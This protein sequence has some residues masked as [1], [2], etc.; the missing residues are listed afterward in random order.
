MKSIILGLFLSSASA[1]TVQ[2]N[3]IDDSQ[4]VQL[5]SIQQLNAQNE[6][7]NHMKI[8]SALIADINDNIAA[9]ELAEENQD[10]NWETLSLH[11]INNL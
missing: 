7:A 2:R 11:M 5:E 6:L 8:H 9:A 1:I 3:F 10:P 4:D